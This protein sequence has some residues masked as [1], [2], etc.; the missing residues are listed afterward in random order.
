M[1][2]IECEVLGRDSDDAIR[3]IKL[4]AQL[5]ESREDW[6]SARKAWTEVLAV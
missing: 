1:L 3:S 4:L 6:T 2:A 5:H